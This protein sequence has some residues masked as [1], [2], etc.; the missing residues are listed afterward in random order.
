VDLASGE[1]GDGTNEMRMASFRKSVSGLRG[2]LRSLLQQQRDGLAPNATSYRECILTQVLQRPLVE[3]QAVV[4]GNV[5]ASGDCYERTLHTLNYMNRLLIRPGMTA[6][7]PFTPQ[8]QKNN[9]KAIE[10]RAL[11]DQYGDG[12]ALLESVVSDPRQRLAKLMPRR[13]FTSTPVKLNLKEESGEEKYEP[14]DYMEFDPGVVNKREVPASPMRPKLEDVSRRHDF[15]FDD[16][17]HGH[18]DSDMDIPSTDEVE[19]RSND[20]TDRAFFGDNDRVSASSSPRMDLK[21]KQQQVLSGIDAVKF[22][23]VGSPSE[24]SSTQPV[25]SMSTSVRTGLRLAQS[26]DDV[27]DWVASFEANAEERPESVHANALPSENAD[28]AFAKQSTDAFKKNPLKKIKARGSDWEDQQHGDT[29]SDQ[30]EQVECPSPNEI[31][32]NEMNARFQGGNAS[33]DGRKQQEADKEIRDT[34]RLEV[35]TPFAE[36]RKVFST[37]IAHWPEVDDDESAMSLSSLHKDV[38]NDVHRPYLSEPSPRVGGTIE[39]FNPGQSRSLTPP[40]P[41]R[42]ETPSRNK[43]IEVTQ[44]AAKSPADDCIGEIHVLEDDVDQ[45]KR[46][47]NGLWETSAASLDRLRRSQELQKRIIEDAVTA[48]RE[49]EAEIEWLEHLVARETEECERLSREYDER[50]EVMESRIQKS[51]T[52]CNDLEKIAEEAIA[53]Q[54]GLEKEL[55]QT[56][57]ELDRFREAAEKATLDYS[58]EV[59]SNKNLAKQLEMAL[60]SLNQMRSDHSDCK[61]VIADL[62]RTIGNLRIENGELKKERDVSQALSIDHSRIVAEQGRL[63]QQFDR[64]QQEMSMLQDENEKLTSNI[65]DYQD[66]LKKAGEQ[67]KTLRVQYESENVALQN[68]VDEWQRRYLQVEDAKEREVQEFRESRAVL[69]TE[70]SD[71]KKQLEESRAEMASLRA[72]DHDLAM[73]RDKEIDMLT[74]EL[75]ELQLERDRDRTLLSDIQQKYERLR[76]DAKE[77]LKQLVK[78]KKAAA[79]TT[80]TL[81]KENAAHGDAN[82]HLR[83]RIEQTERDRESLQSRMNDVLERL[84]VEGAARRE[85]EDRIQHLESSQTRP[86]GTPLDLEDMSS[87]LSLHLGHYS[88]AEQ[89]LL[90]EIEAEK[91]NTERRS[92]SSLTG[93]TSPPNMRT[94][95]KKNEIQQ[96]RELLA[97]FQRDFDARHGSEGQSDSG[98]VPFD[99]YLA[100]QNRRSHAEEL[101]AA[102]GALT[103]ESIEKRNKEI[104]NLKIQLALVADE[105]EAE[106]LRLRSQ[107][108]SLKRESIS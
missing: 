28:K 106:I 59:E 6:R 1:E 33:G 10:S 51:L 69:M 35:E 86:S 72:T 71:V 43:R 53:A 75:R 18:K 84:E 13:P 79:S 102:I 31:D 54:D 83:Y 57:E 81:K 85:A 11:F 65:H 3:C 104:M 55:M 64:C 66:R 15:S 32:M 14:I 2:V 12:G 45:I 24:E 16:S 40:V 58:D 62:E 76:N 25:D 82:R 101:V 87:H 9:A 94:L 90:Q 68:D 27:N 19:N 49:S 100:E 48:R 63:K 108:H 105:K 22:K 88:E 61:D 67:Q 95:N 36:R 70:L 29:G 8:N 91:S 77:K 46:V 73:Q 60:K 34:S 4:L 89:A 93:V 50:M 30:S 20:E 107:L 7:S 42:I 5:H 52:D 56:Q 38:G 92:S 78:E 47:H 96:Q 17:S 26:S 74:S 23:T 21:S 103:K 39:K 41:R 37:P 80:E 97:R 99:A 44:Y 98:V